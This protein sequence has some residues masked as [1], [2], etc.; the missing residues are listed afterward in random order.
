M[1]QHSHC[2]PNVF[3]A[4]LV[5]LM[6]LS[7]CR[8]LVEATPPPDMIIGDVVFA[9][10]SSAIAVMNSVYSLLSQQTSFAQGN[11][12][13]CQ[14]T[15]LAADELAVGK[16][17]P[18]SSFYTN[19]LTPLNFTPRY[20]WAEIYGRI[21]TCNKCL[22]TIPGSKGLSE[23]VKKQL[24]GE[25]KFMRA[26]VY[27]QLVN[28]FGDVP[29]ATVTDYRVN[30]ALFRTPVAQVYTQIIRDLKDAQAAL[31]S[32][33]VNGFGVEVTERVRPNSWAATAMLARV[34]LYSRDWANAESEASKIISSSVFDLAPDPG[35]VFLSTSHEAIFQLQTGIDQNTMDAISYV[36]AGDP[37]IYA[38]NIPIALRPGFTSL[39]EPGDTRPAKWIGQLT[40]PARGATPAI[41]YHYPFKYKARSGPTTEFVMV[42]RLAELYLVRS[43]AR[44]QQGN[45]SGAKDD[46]DKIRNR[47]GLEG[48][49]TTTRQAMLDAIA[50][51]RQVELFTE[52]GHRW[53]DLKRTGT[54]DAVMAAASVQKGSVWNSNAKLFPIPAS[55]I[56]TNPNLTQNT[57]Y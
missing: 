50:H 40:V 24:T 16:A 10:D 27:F 15:G 17:D 52:W 13:I 34:Y 48:I 32:T 42:L 1:E 19:T 6:V 18:R 7:G 44:A 41:T 2:R 35:K 51:E 25:A 43:E 31:G 21:Y 37:A 5:A 56:Q 33:Y 53:F 30:N 14:L 23:S 9:S 22:E 45:L 12:S 20:F 8:K 28:L 29:L 4:I 3:T 57:G 36:L 11:N 47:A 49:T 39:F 46:L 54:I 55:E 26:F 38:S